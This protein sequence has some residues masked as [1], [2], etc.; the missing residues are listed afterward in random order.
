MHLW[1][2]AYWYVCCL[3]VLCFIS[4]S[5][6]YRSP[7]GAM[8]ALA[9]R[10][11]VL[12]P[13]L[14]ISQMSYEWMGTGDWT[15]GMLPWVSWSS[16]ESDSAIPPK[17]PSFPGTEQPLNQSLG[18][19][20]HTHPPKLPTSHKTLLKQL[21]SILSCCS[22]FI[23]RLLRKSPGTAWLR[24]AGS[25]LEKR[26]MA[27]MRWDILL[28]GWRDSTGE[29]RGQLQTDVGLASWDMGH[30]LEIGVEYISYSQ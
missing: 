24:A 20:H 28:G 2:L 26:H 5:H 9:G 8:P 14:H 17:S 3:L 1:G 21:W 4:V 15:S 7:L 30:G 13:A 10:P 23:S 29:S 25:W 6:K 27:G 22:L 19:K 11:L 16:R 12:L 18:R